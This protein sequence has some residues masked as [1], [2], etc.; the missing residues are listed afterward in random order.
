MFFFVLSLYVLLNNYPS[1]CISA[2][3]VDLKQ[4]FTYG[5]Y[6]I[7]V[8]ESTDKLKFCLSATISNNREHAFKKRRRNCTTKLEWFVCKNGK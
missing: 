4:I 1:Y 8:G 6:V 3:S 7:F 5:L 2:F